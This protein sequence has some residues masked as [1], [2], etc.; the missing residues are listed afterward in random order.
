ML[1]P[2]Q[3]LIVVVLFA[4]LWIVAFVVSNLAVWL[5]EKIAN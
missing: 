1:E 4:L 3:K 2:R 5:V